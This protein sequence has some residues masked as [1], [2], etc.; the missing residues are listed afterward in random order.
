MVGTEFIILTIAMAIFFDFW[1]GVNDAANSIATV[2]ATKVLRPWMAVLW[3]AMFNFLGPVLG[4]TAVAA[5]VGKAI[6]RPDFI[7]PELIL[8]ALVGGTA[9]TWVCTHFGLPISVSHSL[10]G[11]LLGAGAAAAG[12]AAWDLPTME[13]VT[14][15]LVLMRDGAIVGTILV[16]L[17]A[18]TLRWRRWALALFIGAFVGSGLWL[19]IHIFSGQI[20]VKGLFATVLFIFYSPML[21]FVGGYILQIITF[22]I[23]QKARPH[24][25]RIGFGVAQLFSSAFYS[26]GHGTNDGQKTM[27]VIAALLLSAGWITTPEGGAFPMPLWVIIASASAI[28]LGTLIGGYKVVH[29]MGHRL[30]HLETHQGFS[31]ETSSAVG[32]Y[33]LAQHGVPVSTTHSITGSILGV[34][35]VRG[36]RKV[37]WGVARTIVAA[38]VLTIPAAA[39]VG[40]I[41]FFVVRFAVGLVGA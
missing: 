36:V 41:T 9:W 33:F 4:G 37:R 5:T 10:I 19:S 27:G 20:A 2:V 7:T 8:A 35:T 22:W 28:A 23:F 6:V 12:M 13:R 31:A 11:G 17:F 32:L 38:W 21:G 29:T 30:T 18:A 15:V 34:G 16:G 39:A 1:N 3:A 26:F 40:A 25:T 24:R 14:P